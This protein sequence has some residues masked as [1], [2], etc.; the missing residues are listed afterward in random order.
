MCK[1]RGACSPCGHSGVTAVDG[2]ER[3]RTF[4]YRGDGSLVTIYFLNKHEKKRE[5]SSLVPRMLPLVYGHRGVFARVI[6]REI[7]P[8]NRGPKRSV[9]AKKGS[10]ERP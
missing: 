7:G 9:T 10:A 5:A 8:K 3:H 2:A 1:I 4:S 6:Q